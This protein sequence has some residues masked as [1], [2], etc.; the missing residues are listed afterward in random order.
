MAKAWKP[1]KGGDGGVSPAQE[2]LAKRTRSGGDTGAGQYV[3][4]SSHIR[5]NER[6]V[7]V[8]VDPTDGRPLVPTSCVYDRAHNRR[9]GAMLMAAARA[10]MVNGVRVV[11]AAPFPA[12]PRLYPPALLTGSGL[13]I[14]AAA[15]ELYELTRRLEG[16]IGVGSDDTVGELSETAMARFRPQR[17]YPT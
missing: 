7:I 3:G 11:V 8:C 17:G 15:D 13:S 4:C 2:V 1:S 6:R 14:D 5:D 12:R 10:M 16:V 9:R